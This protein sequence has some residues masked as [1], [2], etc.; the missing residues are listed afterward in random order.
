VA[1]P[2]HKESH[3]DR[4]IAGP[5]T[6][7]NRGRAGR[8]RAVRADEPVGLHKVR[9]DDTAMA[10]SLVNIGQQVGGPIGWRSSAACLERGGQQPAI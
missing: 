5:V 6:G 7:A 4:R 10:S 1:G 9:N 8:R 3:E 2:N